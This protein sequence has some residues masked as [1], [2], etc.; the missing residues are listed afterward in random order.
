MSEELNIPYQPKSQGRSPGTLIPKNMAIAAQK[1]LSEVEAEHGNIDTFVQQRLGYRSKADM[2][3]RLYAEQ[4][5]SLALA[6]SQRD[7][8]QCF[9]NGDQTGNGKGRF[10]CHAR[11]SGR[12]WL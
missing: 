9:L 2:Y 3:E 5:D 8:G 4:I 1:A 10:G 12:Y 11:G 7:K 6:F